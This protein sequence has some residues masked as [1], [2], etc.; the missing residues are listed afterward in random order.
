[1]REKYPLRPPGGHS[2]AS[3]ELYVVISGR[4][5]ACVGDYSAGNR[6]SG[7]TTEDFGR[8]EH[9]LDRFDFEIAVSNDVHRD[10]D[11]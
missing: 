6:V 4:K 3:V 7:V 10:H 9:W 8:L 2:K 5:L 11:R 1:M